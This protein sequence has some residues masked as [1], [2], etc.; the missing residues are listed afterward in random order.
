MKKIKG[1]ISLYNYGGL[2]ENIPCSYLFDEDIINEELKKSNASETQA[3][4]AI[5]KNLSNAIQT[6]QD[7]IETITGTKP[8]AINRIIYDVDWS[9]IKATHSD[10]TNGVNH[11][12]ILDPQEDEILWVE[13]TSPNW[14]IPVNNHYD[15][16]YEN[17]VKVYEH[18]FYEDGN[19]F[20]KFGDAWRGGGSGGTITG[21]I[22]VKVRA[23]KILKFIDPVMEKALSY[24]YSHTITSSEAYGIE[25]VEGKLLDVEA[26]RITALGSNLS[27]HVQE[28]W[29]DLKTTEDFK[30]LHNLTAFNGP[31]IASNTTYY[32]KNLD[33]LYIPK[34]LTEINGF[35][36]TNLSDFTLKH[37][38]V[39]EGNPVYDSRNNCDCLIRTTD[40]T[41]IGGCMN[42]KI[43]ASVTAIDG[44]W[45]GKGIKRLS[46]P[47][48]LTSWPSTNTDGSPAHYKTFPDLEYLRLSAGVKDY[49][50][51]VISS[52][53]NLKELIIPE[54]IET[55]ASTSSFPIFNTST[56]LLT[57]LELPS[58]FVK[59]NAPAFYPCGGVK[60]L[61]LH[62]D[63]TQDVMGSIGGPMS[64]KEFVFDCE[65]VILDSN[66]NG[67][68]RGAKKITFTNKVKSIP[69]SFCSTISVLEEL[70]F[71]KGITEIPN[72][73]FAGSINK[74][75]K[76]YL[77]KNIKTIGDYAFACAS[78]ATSNLKSIVAP[79]VKTIG[80]SAFI[81][82][83]NLDNLYAPNVET[84]EDNAFQWAA[85][86]QINLPSVKIIGNN[87][88]KD[89]GKNFE[90]ISIPNVERL[91]VDAFSFYYTVTK[92]FVLNCPKLKV[93]EQS[94]LGGYTGKLILG[95]VESFNV[96]T[97]G[98]DTFTTYSP[99]VEINAN[100]PI[101]GFI[102]GGTIILTGDGDA[103]ITSWG[104]TP[105]NVISKVKGNLKAK[106]IRGNNVVAIE[107]GT[108]ELVEGAN[109]YADALYIKDFNK[110]ALTTTAPADLMTIFQNGGPA[111][112]LLKQYSSTDYTYD[113]NADKFSGEININ[114]IGNLTE[115]QHCVFF[116]MSNHDVTFNIGEGITKIGKHAFNTKDKHK[117]NVP[118]SVI[119]VEE[120][121]L[122]NTIP[123]FYGTPPTG[124]ENA[125]YVGTIYVKH[126]YLEQ[127]QAVEWQGNVTI[128][129]MDE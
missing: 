67:I 5:N 89:F 98:S 77:P 116:G 6:L 43:P 78:N 46:L 109:T 35:L 17:N 91:G 38:I 21:V 53:P 83:S 126:E 76:L 68:I 82:H 7:Q 9:K 100:S 2:R 42:S 13:V 49:E 110:Y 44:W 52:C 94:S 80:N 20:I 57:T 104:L 99:V 51:I 58:T 88:F 23:A 11:F 97:F 124:I 10:Y 113:H 81:N 79:G 119:E 101:T 128:E 27:N 3:I 4:N 40:N 28:I 96:R 24:Y 18:K 129:V 72:Y 60:K 47:D 61:I 54:G 16:K 19:L 73:A 29:K 1:R 56:P 31:V 71:G 85:P 15:Y 33:T 8:D 62:C 84:I 70:N 25:H 41:M 22:T 37:I 125:F 93:T 48:T 26:E 36:I 120:Y 39:E 69:Q 12:E 106:L 32:P 105:R 34:S 87:A 117:I 123:Y 103:D 112:V 50:G 30:L 102:P 14:S 107:D 95:T 55:I 74:L 122:V 127:W 111:L 92:E 118:A 59:C 115:I 86:K 75:T 65:N 114:P 64:I 45:Y 90:S 108:I 63:Y 66:T 121:C